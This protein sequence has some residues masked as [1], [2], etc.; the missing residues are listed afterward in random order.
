MSAGHFFMGV[1]FLGLLTMSVLA[2]AAIGQGV[3]RTSHYLAGRKPAYLEPIS[4]QPLRPSAPDVRRMALLEQWVSSGVVDLGLEF[5]GGVFISIA[6]VG[7]PEFEL[8][9]QNSVAEAIDHA[10]A[11]IIKHEKGEL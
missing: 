10:E 9:Y 6:L 4:R 3:T 11:E 8:R 1:S 2:I 5:D 7:G